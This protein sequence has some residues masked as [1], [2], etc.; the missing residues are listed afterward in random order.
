MNGT[1]HARNSMKAQWVRVSEVDGAG[2]ARNNMSAQRVRASCS[3]LGSEA[4]GWKL[5]VAYRDSGLSMCR[6]VLVLVW[7]SMKA[8]IERMACM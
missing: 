7:N 8:E 6:E 1:G 2:H 3:G 4:G 5:E